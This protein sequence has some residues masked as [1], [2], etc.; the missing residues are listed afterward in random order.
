MSQ[1]MHIFALLKL[2]HPFYKKNP[3]ITSNTSSL[4]ND[5]SFNKG[6]DGFMMALAV[7][8]FDTSEPRSDTNYVR[9]IVHFVERIDGVYNEM[10]EELHPC[11]DVDMAKFYPPEDPA[12]IEKLQSGGHLY[13]LDW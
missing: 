10:R 1:T 12:K 9:W 5:A 8:N 6:A 4:G 3:S 13:C 7:E 2:E 11:T